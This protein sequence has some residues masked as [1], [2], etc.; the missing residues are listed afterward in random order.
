MAKEYVC[1]GIDISRTGLKIALA[2]PSQKK[3]FKVDSLPA[4]GDPLADTSIYASALSSW[5]RSNVQS[6]FES[7]AVS[8]PAG[9]GLIRTVEI[10]KEAKNA[11][12]Y[13]QWEFSSAVE[14]GKA[15]EILKIANAEKSD[16]YELDIAFYPNEKKA[17][18]A[19]VTALKRKFIDSFCSPDVE[20]NG[21][22]PACLTA[23]IIATLN[24]LEVTEGLGSTVKCILK[25]DDHSVIAVWGDGSG[26]LAIRTAEP[27]AEAIIKI[28]E[29]G[30]SQ[31]SKAKRVVKFC[32]ELTANKDF[33]DELIKQAAGLPQGIKISVW[34]AVSK[35]SLEKHGN[36]S[37][38]SECIAA[39]GVTLNCV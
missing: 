33:T 5:I 7:I 23:D 10:P 36:F 9:Y 22:R 24:L 16:D 13:V 18:R 29:S 20:K 26:P 38:L 34:D 37:K 28:L 3:I 19:T 30:F 15:G 1:L 11:T 2:D 32:G 12:D 39:V 14:T 25:A 17:E 6:K 31:F 4:S 8:F 35:F 21:L 27:S